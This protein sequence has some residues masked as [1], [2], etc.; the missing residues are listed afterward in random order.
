MSKK[1]DT[2]TKKQIYGE[3]KVTITALDDL[4]LLDCMARV[5]R[6]L[7]RGKVTGKGT[8]YPKSTQF[9]DNVVVLH[10]DRPAPNLKFRV[11]Y[12]KFDSGGKVCE[13]TKGEKYLTMRVDG[14]HIPFYFETNM[15]YFIEHY[16]TLGYEVVVK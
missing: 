7:S 10:D 16:K 14:M 5:Y 15:E 8:G 3:N 4:P 12:S 9:K 1:Q 6:I 13:I 2:E 11:K